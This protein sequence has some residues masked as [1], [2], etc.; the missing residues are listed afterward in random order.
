MS[1]FDVFYQIW[2]SLFTIDLLNLPGKLPGILESYPS[3]F[4]PERFIKPLAKPLE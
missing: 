2:S 1:I 3:Y 4:S